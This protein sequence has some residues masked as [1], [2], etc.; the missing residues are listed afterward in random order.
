MIPGANEMNAYMTGFDPHRTPQPLPER[1]EGFSEID[2]AIRENRLTEYRWK[3]AWA[4]PWAR[5][6]TIGGAFVIL[7]VFSFLIGA[8]VGLW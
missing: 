7:A 6:L 3:K 5:K 1:W 8:S 2:H 4:D